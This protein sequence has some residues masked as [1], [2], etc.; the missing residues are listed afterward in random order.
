MSATFFTLNNPQST[1]CWPTLHERPGNQY[2]SPSILCKVSTSWSAIL[3]GRDQANMI[4]R[5]RLATRIG[6]V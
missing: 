4:S 6:K 2:I 5:L 1:L 3:D